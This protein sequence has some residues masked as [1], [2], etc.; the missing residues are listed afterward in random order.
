ML[1]V[2]T[3]ISC[4]VGSLCHSRCPCCSGLVFQMFLFVLVCFILIEIS[5]LSK[6]ELLMPSSLYVCGC[7]NISRSTQTLMV[8]GCITCIC[9]EKIIRWDGLMKLMSQKHVGSIRVELTSYW[10]IGLIRP[11][12]TILRAFTSAFSELFY[13]TIL[14]VTLLIILYHF[15]ILNTLNFYLSH[16]FIKILISPSLSLSSSS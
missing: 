9:M 3:L 4:W 5:E 12:H 6:K 16:L 13:F 10:N 11:S 15:N 8:D 7:N 2:A 14:K 1:Q